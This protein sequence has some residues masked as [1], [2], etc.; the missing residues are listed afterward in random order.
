MNERK[1]LMRLT[2]DEIKNILVARRDSAIS[3][4]KTE[5]QRF[6]AKH[7]KMGFS[8]MSGDFNETDVL[9]HGRL[10]HSL[11]NDILKAQQDIDTGYAK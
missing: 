8:S 4:Y 3:K 1:T 10:V 5:V 6:H 2:D 7:E 9:V 11:L